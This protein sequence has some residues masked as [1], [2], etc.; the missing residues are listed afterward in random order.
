MLAGDP[1]A[2][3]EHAPEWVDA[4]CAAGPYADASRLYRPPTAASSCCRWSAAPGPPASAAGCSPTRP[5]GGWAAW[6]APGSDAEVAGAVLADLRATGAQRFGIRPDPLRATPGRAPWTRLRSTVTRIPRRAHVIDL[7]RRRRRGL[8]RMSKS[9]RRGIRLAERAGVRVEVDRE[10]R[11][12]RRLLPALP[13]LGG[14]LGGAAARA[15]GA[16]PRPGPPARPAGQAA[17]HGGPAGQ[18]VRSRWPTS[19]T[20]RPSAR[21]PCSARPPTTR[22]PRW[23]STG[24]QDLRR[25]PRPVDGVC[26]WPASWAAPPSTSASPGLGQPGPVQGEVRRPAVG[27]RRAPDRAAAVH[28]RR[29][30]G[31]RGW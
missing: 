29:P 6:S 16:G 9:A 28:P 26:S 4:L 19:T 13:D 21:S 23:T 20:S 2:L 1:A 25:R 17:G 24:R 14:P 27:L 31:P 8:R 7:A 3:P 22:A 10:R 5:A 15:A 11:A 12:A 30:G 18:G